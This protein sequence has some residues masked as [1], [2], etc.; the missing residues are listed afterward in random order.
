M[1][2][3]PNTLEETGSPDISVKELVLRQRMIKDAIF[4]YGLVI[5]V[6]A[7]AC[8]LLIYFKL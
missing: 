7:G 8:G 4:V 5:S 3:I 1:A 6:I 2:M